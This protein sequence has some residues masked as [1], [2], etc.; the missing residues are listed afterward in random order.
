MARTGRRSAH[1]Q[2][3][4]R[5]LWSGGVELERAAGGLVPG[6]PR[7]SCSAIGADARL[8]RHAARPEGQ[9][10]PTLRT[11]VSTVLNTRFAMLLIWGPDLVMVYNDG[12]APMLGLRHPKALGRRVPD[13]WDD[14][15]ADIQ[16]M[17]AEVFA[18]GATGISRTCRW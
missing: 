14:V 17:I 4:E 1:R 13:V 16:P 8:G 15:W 12:Y 11:A 3:P 18:G 7:R 5:D 6:H 10:S 2:R 9:W